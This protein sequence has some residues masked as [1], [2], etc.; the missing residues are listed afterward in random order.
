MYRIMAYIQIIM[1]IYPPVLKRHVKSI[2]AEV[3]QPQVIGLGER[4]YSFY[5]P[6]VVS[7]LLFLE[8][9]LIISQR[10]RHSLFIVAEQMRGY[11][12]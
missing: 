7:H 4:R 8:I 9:E 5:Y 12:F 2:V 6:R 3:Q 1:S 11:C 10:Y